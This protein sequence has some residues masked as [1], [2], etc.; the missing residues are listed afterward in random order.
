MKRLLVIAA[1]AAGFA[2][3]SFGAA[4]SL[5]TF[6]VNG[7]ETLEIGNTQGGDKVHNNAD[8]LIDLQGGSTLSITNILGTTAYLWSTLICTNGPAVL[9]LADVH[10]AFVGRYNIIVRAPGSLVVKSAN[11]RS[12]SFGSDPSSKGTNN[13][14]HY[15]LAG[16]TYAD[17]EGGDITSSVTNSFSIAANNFAQAVL[18]SMPNPSVTVSVAAGKTL[19]LAGENMFP[20]QDVVAFDGTAGH[21]NVNFYLLNT[22][23][24]ASTQK[25]TLG[26]WRT[27]TLKP[28]AKLDYA[29]THDRV[30][31]S[32]TDNGY[33]FEVDM[34]SVNATVTVNSWYGA[35]MT[36]KISGNG[37][38]RSDLPDNSPNAKSTA[39][40]TGDLSGFVGSVYVSKLNTMELNLAR[41][42]GTTTLF[43]GAT[44]KFVAPADG[45]PAQVDVAA[46]SATTTPDQPVA[47]SAAAGQK[48]SVGTAEGCIKLVGDAESD[49]DAIDIVVGGD[50]GAALTTDGSV[51]VTFNGAAQPAACVGS[52]AADGSIA[53]FLP[54]PNGEVVVPAQFCM[55]VSTDPVYY[56][57]G[58][59]K[60]TSMP[61]G[62]GLK[63]GDGNV[64]TVLLGA[65][66][67][68]SAVGAL[69]GVTVKVASKSYNWRDK[70]FLWLDPSDNSTVFLHYKGTNPSSQEF[71]QP[72]EWSVASSATG[73]DSGYVVEGLADKRGAEKTT[74]RAWQG[75]SYQNFY[76][77]SGNI[78]YE[79]LEYV[80]PILSSYASEDC[81]NKQYLAFGKGGSRRISFVD[82][83]EGV[84][85]TNANDKMTSIPA[86]FA[87][88]VFG[89]QMGGGNCLIAT[90]NSTFTRAGRT[91]EEPISKKSVDM[92]VNGKKID[93]T[94]EKFSGGWD[95]F[96]VDLTQDPNVTGLGGQGSK[97]S[98]NPGD[99]YYGEMLFFS[100]VLTDDQR[101]EV[102][103]YLAEGWGLMEKYDGNRRVTG[104]AQLAGSG[105]V[106][107]GEGVEVSAS[108]IFSGTLSVGAG[109]VVNL[110]DGFRPYTEAQISALEP[111]LWVDPSQPNVITANSV[112]Q[113]T[114]I[115]Q[116]DENKRG[117]DDIYLAANGTGRS[118]IYLN[119][120]RAFGPTLPWIDYNGTN[121]TP[122]SSNGNTL[123]MYTANAKND[124]GEQIDQS[125]NMKMGFIVQDSMRGGGT[126]FLDN[127]LASGKVKARLA[128]P[129][130]YPMYETDTDTRLTQGNVYLNGEQVDYKN[131]FTGGPEVFTFTATDSFPV[132]YY[133][134]IGNSQSNYTYK[135]G[136]IQGEVM[137]F[138]DVL[139]EADRKGIEAYLMKKWFGFGPAGSVDFSGAQLDGAGT[140]VVSSG[141]AAP[142]LASTFSGTLQVGGDAGVLK[143][144]LVT[145][146]GVST[147]TDAWVA[148]E[149]TLYLPS[150][151]TIAIDAVGRPRPGDYVVVSAKSLGETV[152]TLSGNVQE[153]RSGVE[154]IREGNRVILR[155]SAGG[156]M[157]LIQ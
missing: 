2:T 140:L 38:I 53:C 122:T 72:L 96:S 131:G 13:F 41:I 32:T 17:A 156:M 141:A 147:L 36:G 145:A 79:E 97:A 116:H 59:V 21:L 82:F 4:E 101:E 65:A 54:N 124:K 64:P 154:L 39:S 125:V 144:T 27:M 114:K 99:K 83:T 135:Y 84:N 155:I 151:V 133:A 146:N 120:A 16:I 12:Y 143:T 74:W 73:N 11:C 22:K 149:A 70:A 6:T 136:E 128:K 90:A 28:V 18:L 132:G 100:E 85:P 25:V 24:F 43:H 20:N 142:K 105:T 33:D 110:A 10:T 117:G 106:E 152:F 1:L 45:G 92:W 14:P 80:H 104:A 157:M 61:T 57:I 37:T 123:R 81:N 50:Q 55:P 42:D 62:F 98:T 94:A 30:W 86:K 138:A 31:S 7:G 19:F 137:L 63:P 34:L 51:A 127:I 35:Q 15:D 134:Y 77:T 102:E 87:V 126:P 115:L 48:V 113:V 112:K 68:A 52:V 29:T 23:V 69:P 150:A 88:F 95:V 118:P 89:S 121:E 129:A 91:L 44:L 103:R 107:V 111:A 109:S 130:S 108:G 5:T 71:K 56:T 26:N 49:T 3:S 9:Q 153:S 119:Q 60:V 66:G 47:S 139:P 93:P 8:V 75:R 76:A 67:A 40:F 78:G 58:K 148:E 46:V